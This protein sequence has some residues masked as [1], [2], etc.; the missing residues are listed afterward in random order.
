MDFEQIGMNAARI[1]DGLRKI[2]YTPPTAITD[3]VDNS[4]QAQAKHVYIRTI[5]KLVTDRRRDNVEAYEIID[6]GI[7][8]NSVGI[9]SALELGSSPDD[10]GV[11]SLSKFGL[12]LKSAAF[13][14]GEVLEVI[15]SDGSDDFCKYVVSLPEI[16]RRQ[17][18]GAMRS[19]LTEEDRALIARYL[20]AGKG[21]IVRIGSVR[22]ENHPTIRSTYNELR[23]RLGAIYYYYMIDEMVN[24]VLGPYARSS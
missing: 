2:G 3:I 19:E 13:S 15:S 20:P 21:T 10:Y 5:P 4:V 6:D 16:R 11:H 22:E 14:Q 23:Q 1:C 24:I 9:K 7:G 18:Y 8:M 12:G 17:E